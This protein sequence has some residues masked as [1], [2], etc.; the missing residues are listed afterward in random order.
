MERLD[1][2]WNRSHNNLQKHY[3]QILNHW[4]SEEP[5]QALRSAAFDQPGINMKNL[6]G[7]LF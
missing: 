7:L 5:P 6:T 2:P 3:Q 4:S 1:L